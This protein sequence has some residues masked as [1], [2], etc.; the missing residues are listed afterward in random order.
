MHLLYVL[1]MYIDEY[2]LFKGIPERLREKSRLLCA[3]LREREVVV[4]AHGYPDDGVPG[5]HGKLQ[6]HHRRVHEV[7]LHVDIGKGKTN[8][9]LQGC[10]WGRYIVVF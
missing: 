7:L 5:P 4:H 10:V 8:Q 6:V 2:F 9:K 3:E 1:Y